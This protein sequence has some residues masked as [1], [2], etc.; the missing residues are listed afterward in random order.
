MTQRIFW[1]SVTWRKGA[2]L[3]RF[4]VERGGLYG[5]LT[6][7]DGKAMMLPMV[8]WD[9]LL[10]A[11]RGQRATKQRSEQQFP[12]RSRSRWYDGET[13]E[14]VE[15]FKSGRTIEQLARAHSR[16][17]YAV[18]AQLDKLGLFSKADKYGPPVRPEGVGV[19]GRS[20]GRQFGGQSRRRRQCPLRAAAGA[21]AGGAAA[22][23]AVARG[24]VQGAVACASHSPPS[25]VIW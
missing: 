1:E 14:L 13:T 15:G 7:P 18:E 24:G 2:D 23:V 11:L 5:S 10:D 20:A 16:S 17:I 21:L 8:V 19:A 3:Y 25:S 6:T 12:V 4:D 22:A 9:G